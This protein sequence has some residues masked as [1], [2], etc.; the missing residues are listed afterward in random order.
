M[1]PIFKSFALAATLLA[2]AKSLAPL[3]HAC[4]HSDGDGL[5]VAL[6]L[7]G[8]GALASTQVGALQIIEEVGVPVHCVVGTSM[9]SAIGALYVSGYS[10]E[11]IH[12][13]FTSEDWGA[14]F[15]G[16]IDRVKQ[17]FLSKEDS[18]F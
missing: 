2:C 17:P 6:V 13:I 8:G 5:D 16:D 9:G 3:A 11:E 1:T 14:I 12:E 7:S 10:A 18:E 15:R 4:D